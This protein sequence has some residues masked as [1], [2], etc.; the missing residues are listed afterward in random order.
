MPALQDHRFAGADWPDIIR[1]LTFLSMGL[2]KGIGLLG[3]D[4]VMRGL[5]VSP[6]DLAYGTVAKVLAD[7]VRYRKDKGPLLPFLI[8]V[9][10]R[11]FIDLL[12][13]KAWLTTDIIDGDERRNPQEDGTVGLDSLDSNDSVMPDF[14]LRK[15]IMKQVKDDQQLVDYT[16]A[17]LEMNVT[18]PADFADL[19]STT[20]TDIQNRKKRLF[21]ALS[22]AP[23][24]RG[25]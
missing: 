20:V 22:K 5:G 24:L 23:N 15:R 11:D 7:E 10:K 1:R 4:A 9:L 14:I 2:F 3:P 8:L 18:K 17:A 13:Q 6:E 19:L 16:I 21:R 12:R 25:V